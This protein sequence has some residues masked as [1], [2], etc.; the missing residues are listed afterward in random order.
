MK[1]KLFSAGPRLITAVALAF[2]VTA[3]TGC[4]R[5]NPTTGATATTAG[6]TALE[7]A[8][9]VWQQGDQAG[10]IQRILETD[11]KTGPIFS[12]G[13]ALAHKESELS[14]MGQAEM[15]KV[16]AEAQT[17]ASDFKK[18][19]AALR[20][21][22]VAAAAGDRELARRC[23]SRLDDLGAALEQ[24]G[25]LQIVRLNGQAIRRMA[26]TESAKLGQ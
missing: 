2:V 1:P 7:Q 5:K 14:G 10:A 25:G 9:N 13:S 8:L 22:G 21:K 17:C 6:P 16:V 3:F 4:G 24:S 26:A 23:F 19:A 12:P 18:L 15:L 20:D 11:W